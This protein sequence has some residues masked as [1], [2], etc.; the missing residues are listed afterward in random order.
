MGKTRFSVTVS[1]DGY[2]AGPDQSEDNPLGVGG[3]D[4][5][6]WLFDMEAWRVSHGESG[7]RV[8]PS[9]RVVD[10]LE[11]GYGAVVMGRNMFGPIR[12]EWGESTWRGWWGDDPPYHTPVYVLTHHPRESLEMEGGTTFHSSPTAPTRL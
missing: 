1:L 10:E 4:L 2:M 11:S 12:G 8:D 3:M 6:R 9:T 5:H 7:G